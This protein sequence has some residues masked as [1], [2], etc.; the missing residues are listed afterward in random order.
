MSNFNILGFFQYFTDQI[1]YQTILHLRD[2]KVNSNYQ[3]YI[4]P[5]LF[6]KEHHVPIG[7]EPSSVGVLSPSTPHSKFH[8]SV[9][10]SL[11]LSTAL[12]VKGKPCIKVENCYLQRKHW[13]Q[14][15][16]ENFRGI[17]V[18]AMGLF[19]ALREI[20]VLLNPYSEKV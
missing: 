19:T 11:T 7:L 4:F 14:C 13:Y 15:C 2:L 10:M 20:L 12:L 18:I 5:I 1:F 17:T 3:L 8:S 6:I 9:S 16:E